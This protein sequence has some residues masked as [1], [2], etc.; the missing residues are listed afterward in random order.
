[1]EAL[2]DMKRNKLP[3]LDGTPYEFYKKIWENIKDFY[4]HAVKK[5]EIFL[6]KI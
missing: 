4:Y 2:F 1:M 3:G 5:I 6:K